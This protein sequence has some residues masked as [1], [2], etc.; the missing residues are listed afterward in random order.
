MVTRLAQRSGHSRRAC[1]ERAPGT[2]DRLRRE[3]GQL[4]L[5]IYD[6]AWTIER[7]AADLAAWARERGDT[8]CMLGVDSIQTVRC[9]AELAGEREMGA[10]QAIEAR[11]HALRAVA[12]EHRLI[13][14]ATSEMSRAAYRSRATRE[15]VDALAAS[16]WSGAI[17]YSAR[18]LLA[19]RSVPDHPE[20]VE[21]EIAKNKHG[22]PRPP[23]YLR[24]DRA[25][26][27]L[28]ETEAPA[29]DEERA[30]DRDDA[31][32]AA[33]DGRTRRDAARV[34]VALERSPGLSARLVQR[35][36]PGIGEGRVT[37][38][39][40]ALGPA[41]VRVLGP[42][43]RQGHYLDGRHVPDA[44]L[45]ELGAEDRARVAAARP[46]APNESGTGESDGAPCA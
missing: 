31:R 9:D 38:A 23:I 30:A 37:A 14:I 33:A 46:P 42:G 16:K 28:A 18:V 15:N 17:E 35:C 20:L 11:V 5:R 1:E 44:V 29:V 25:S 36:V 34:A 21:V 27:Q 41:V 26:Q 13:A 10:P 12:T 43:R 2:L 6:A 24:I 19:L 39:L 45:R 7:A 8:R 3:L 40:V 32:V 4:P 22:P